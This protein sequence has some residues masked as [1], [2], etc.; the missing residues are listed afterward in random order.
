[1][2]EIDR[3]SIERDFISSR[4]KE[5]L[6]KRKADGMKLGRPV[7][8]ARNLR[9]DPM[10]SKIDDYLAKGIDKRSIAK[11]LCVSPGTI[12]AWLKV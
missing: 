7:V 12:Y 9:Q 6:A 5:A 11:L 3:E 2:L 10:A 1:V 8:G 4:T